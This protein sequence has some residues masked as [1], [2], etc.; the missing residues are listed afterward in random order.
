MFWKKRDVSQFQ[1]WELEPREAPTIQEVPTPSSVSRRRMA[2]RGLENEKLKLNDNYLLI[3]LGRSGQAAVQH[4][5][6]AL[7]R[8]AQLDLKR[9]RLLVISED[10]YN[11]HL[12]DQ[13]I[14][15][16]SLIGNGEPDIEQMSQKLQAW[17]GEFRSP[18][19][20]FCVDLGDPLSRFLP[21][22]AGCL[23]LLEDHFISFS[24]R[25]VLIDS[26]ASRMEPQETL[27]RL[28]EYMRFSRPEIK[29]NMLMRGRKKDVPQLF[30]DLFV[31][32]RQAE[33]A[34]GEFLFCLLHPSSMLIHQQLSNLRTQAQNTHWARVSSFS[35]RT[36]KKEVG[37]LKA[38]T[39]WQ[40]VDRILFGFETM[41]DDKQIK[42]NGLFPREE[43]NP[44]GQAPKEPAGNMKEI[45][46]RI[47][48]NLP[49]GW[50]FED[51]QDPFVIPPAKIINDRFHKNFAGWL[52]YA[53]NSH[54]TE[55]SYFVTSQSFELLY[56]RLI[57]IKRKLGKLVNQKS[58]VSLLYSAASKIVE[59]CEVIKKDMVDWGQQFQ[60]AIDTIQKKSEYEL[61]LLA[62]PE[63][64]LVNE[65]ILEDKDTLPTIF[66]SQYLKWGEGD[67]RDQVASIKWQVSNQNQLQLWVAQKEYIADSSDPQKGWLAAL[68]KR[69]GSLTEE[70]PINQDGRMTLGDRDSAVN[71]LS[72]L[73]NMPFLGYQ[74]NNDMQVKKWSIVFSPRDFVQGLSEQVFGNSYILN[75]EREAVYWDIP[76]FTALGVH[77]GIPID[78]LDIYQNA[79]D[80]YYKNQG[81]NQDVHFLPEEA[82]ARELEREHRVNQ[83]YSAQVVHTL[84]DK[85]LV[86]LFL[87]AHICGLIQPLLWQNQLAWGIDTLEPF[88][89]VQLSAGAGWDEFWKVYENFT[90][91]YMADNKSLVQQDL[92]GENGRNPFSNQNRVNYLNNL[93]QLINSKWDER[94]KGRFLVKTLPEMKRSGQGENT[95]FLIRML[96]QETQKTVK[97]DLF[98]EHFPGQ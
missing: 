16:I 36:S 86:Y 89:S 2:G 75:A 55:H 71:S 73:G 92:G 67:H 87:R 21:L 47:P 44:A 1:A 37:R 57:S 34:L 27:A 59:V 62:N 65:F 33:A 10:S 12:E 11:F 9:I 46:R 45:T 14:F 97:L 56:D 66:N 31:V 70:F 79:L 63:G 77:Y 15:K 8:E 95:Q 30:D 58:E 18:R 80:S 96:E 61:R 28:R 82:W 13:H 3:A 35:I 48:D 5:L 53:L 6:S 83:F 84:W 98:P 81:S 43:L 4:G 40:A 50:F 88:S 51:N 20:Y 74:K 22:L 23:T 32:D 25:T 94:V 60:A 54:L 72:E 78:H 76:R 93:V 24:N 41:Q 19:V 38:W 39:A 49:F 85:R 42:W 52:R 26:N 7:A 91:N 17:A 68:Y 69:A 90:V 29:H 64:N